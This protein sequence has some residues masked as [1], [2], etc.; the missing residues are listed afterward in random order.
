MSTY[1]IQEQHNCLFNC[2][3]DVLI[4]DLLCVSVAIQT[5]HTQ[6]N[7]HPQT[8]THNPHKQTS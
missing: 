4:I 3:F 7:A 1:V 8:Q 5:L 6:T 2:W